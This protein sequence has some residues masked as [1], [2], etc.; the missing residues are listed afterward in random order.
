MYYLTTQGKK[1]KEELQNKQIHLQI[2][3]E[4]GS[5]FCGIYSSVLVFNFELLFA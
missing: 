3:S 4:R 2:W 1:E 5:N